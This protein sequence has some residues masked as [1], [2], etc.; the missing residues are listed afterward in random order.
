MKT[1]Y[2]ETT[3]RT[4]YSNDIIVSVLM[5]ETC[6]QNGIYLTK[7][8]LIKLYLTRKTRFAC[9]DVEICQVVFVYAFLLEEIIQLWIVEKI[10]TKPHFH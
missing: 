1:M 8:Y 2:Q 3:M 4:M 6:W 9:L 10:L 7:L 5:T